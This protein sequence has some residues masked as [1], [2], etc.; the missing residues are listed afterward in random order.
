MLLLLLSIDGAQSR[1]KKN[2]DAILE[3]LILDIANGDTNALE[4]LYRLT[5]SS[6]YGFA[7]SILKKSHEAEDIMHDA[8]VKIYESAGTYR[9][10]GKPMAWILTIVR[11]LALSRFRSKDESNLPLKEDW[12]I[13]DQY[14]FTESSINQMLLDKLLKI[15]SD[16]E[17]QIVILHSI[18]GL[19]HREISE[20]LE[21][22]LSTTLSK[23]HR[24]LSKL[25]I[26]LKGEAK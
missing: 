11:N 10:L 12:I 20:I 25:R 8:Y 15:L 5:D 22:P 3:N 2:K 24:S 18:T 7:L 14:D 21:I 1:A 6:V 16:E 13:S 19:K 4:E 9:P 26:L 17:R 23:Y